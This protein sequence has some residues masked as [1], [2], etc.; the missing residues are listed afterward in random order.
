M[1]FARVVS[2]EAVDKARIEQLKGRVEGEERPEG[3]PATEMLLLH[4]H[5]E[6]TALAILFFDT[7]EDYQRGNETLSAMPDSETPGKRTS[8]AKYEVAFRVTA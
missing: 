8:V 2:F 6:A 3:V 4:D 7:E 1:A 5:N